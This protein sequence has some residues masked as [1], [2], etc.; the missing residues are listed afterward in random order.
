[1]GYSPEEAEQP[2]ASLRLCLPYP[3]AILKRGTQPQSDGLYLNAW[4]GRQ[5]H[6]LLLFLWLPVQRSGSSMVGWGIIPD[7]S[8]EPGHGRSTILS[9]QHP[10]TQRSQH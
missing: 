2:G 9:S 3:P 5:L 1:M 4:D 6:P 7:L 8:H 10:A